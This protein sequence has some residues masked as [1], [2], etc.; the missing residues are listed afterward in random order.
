MKKTI[1]F[2][3]LF[4][5]SNFSYADGPYDGIY[6]INLNGF[7][8]NYVTIH[9]NDNQVVAIIID[10]VPS[11]TWIPLTGVRNGDSL[12]AT[13]ING[14]HAI[15]IKL[16]VTVNFQDNGVSTGTVDSC[17]NGFFYVCKF[18]SGTELNLVK[19]F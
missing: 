2:V 4:T 18:Q 9:E 13:S 5:I 10:V 6:A 19:I 16:N 8:T 14:A 12:T 3:L 17:V 11:S 15:D 1:I 7:V